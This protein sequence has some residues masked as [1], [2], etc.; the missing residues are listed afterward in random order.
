MKTIEII[1]DPAGEARLQTRGYGGA[2]CRDASRLLE[3]ALGTVQ[4]DMP[5]PEMYQ[6]QTEPQ[7]VR[8]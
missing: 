1:V 7:Q 4:S 8:Q 6:S 2:S 5:T 3:Q